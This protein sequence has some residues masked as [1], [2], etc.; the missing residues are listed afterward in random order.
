MKILNILFY[1][2]LIILNSCNTNDND[3]FKNNNKPT[4]RQ[5]AKSGIKHDTDPKELQKEQPKS[6]EELLRENLSDDQKTYLDWLKTALTNAGEFDKFLQHDVGKIKTAL[7]HIQ[8]E[9]TK[10]E[11]KQNAD[12][13]ENDFKQIIQG[14]LSGGDID[15]VTQALSL[16]EVLP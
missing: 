10:C 11:G 16:C 2:F 3:T 5:Q 12:Q 9:L 7:D 4:E 13:R 8:T 6:K 1:L 14:A 15:N